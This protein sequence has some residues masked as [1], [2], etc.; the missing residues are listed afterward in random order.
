MIY[1]D[2][3]IAELI[4]AVYLS[5][6][7]TDK[8]PEC[9][10][11]VNPDNVKYLVGKV[12]IINVPDYSLEKINQMKLNGCKIITRYWYS[13]EFNYE[14]YI[15]RI[16]SGINWNGMII[17]TLSG[18]EDCNVVLDDSGKVNLYFPKIKKYELTDVL[19][20][21][22]NLSS[23]GWALQQVGLNIIE[24]T[25]FSDLDLIKTN[26]ILPRLHDIPYK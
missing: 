7:I 10:I 23:L 21:K 17:E 8:M 24:S 26:K 19:D 22:G 18:Y 25:Y 12:I 9:N 6:G 2:N 11:Y 3:N 4:E 5:D 20:V 1:F 14:P 13:D 16:N 15:L